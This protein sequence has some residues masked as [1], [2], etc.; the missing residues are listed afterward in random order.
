MAVEEVVC[1]MCQRQARPV[2]V[3][4]GIES[5]S[6]LSLTSGSSPFGPPSFWRKR[7]ISKLR[8]WLFLGWVELSSSSLRRSMWKTK[9]KLFCH[10]FTPALF[11]PSSSNYL[12][13]VL[14]MPT[15]CF[16]LLCSFPF[17]PF[18]PGSNNK[19]VEKKD[20]EKEK[21]VEMKDFLPIFS[22]FFYL[23]VCIKN[24]IQRTWARWRHSWRKSRRKSKSKRMG[25]PWITNR[26][27]SLYKT[28]QKTES[29][30]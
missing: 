28:R 20:E 8:S 9:S 24:T 15:C 5:G 6:G 14:G 1:Y 4:F 16:A 11:L 30:L 21:E 26:F 29:L 13:S 17:L 18:F 23:Q 25:K 2:T 27:F 12:D 22:H 3:V 7:R 19:V 10:L